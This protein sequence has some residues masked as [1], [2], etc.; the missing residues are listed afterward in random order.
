ME[1]TSSNGPTETVQTNG[2]T[3][4]STLET[5]PANQVINVKET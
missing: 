1:K 5:K 4:P 3:E 2:E